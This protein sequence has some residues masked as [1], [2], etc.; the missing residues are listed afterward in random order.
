[1]VQLLKTKQ[2]LIRRETPDGPI[3]SRRLSDPRTPALALLLRWH[4]RVARVRASPPAIAW[5]PLRRP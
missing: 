3:G 5:T 4:R 2:P 1:M